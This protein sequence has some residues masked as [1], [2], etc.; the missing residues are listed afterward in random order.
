VVTRRLWRDTEAAAYAREALHFPGLRVLV[1]VDKEERATGAV[2]SRETRSFAYSGDPSGVSAAEL[3]GLARGHWGVENRLHFIKD[4]WW[5]EDRHYLCRPGLAERLALL[6]GAALAVLRL[7]RPDP[8]Q[9]LRARADEL[10]HDVEQATKIMTQ[11]N[12]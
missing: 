10:S 4:R 5:D 1:R 11:K 9:P 8:K 6:L 7:T 3:L 2:T 12:L